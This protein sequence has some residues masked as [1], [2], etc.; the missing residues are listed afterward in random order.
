[1]SVL[2]S[3][4]KEWHKVTGLPIVEGYGLS[5]TSPVVAF[6]PMTIAKF[7]GKIGIPA[8]NTDVVLIDEDDNEV[9]IGER[10]EICVKG[11]QVMI[12]YQNRPD[13]TAD[14]F[15]D[16]GYLKTGDIGIMDEK[17]FIKIVDRKKDM[18]LVSGFNV[19][20]NEIEEAMSEH[21]AVKE[22]GAIGVPNDERGEDPK[23]FVVKKGDVTEQELIDFGKKQLTGYKRP[24]HVQFVDELPK[25]NVGKILRKE[26]R[27]MEGL[28]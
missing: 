5:E 20:P 26:L 2:P 10:G 14:T 17:G 19:Y 15:T 6:N 28:E 9:A 11:P 16:S 1:M 13:E 7:T 23:I 18:I 25:S 24:R 12:G 4:A 3:V 22:V 8:S 27:K 21:A